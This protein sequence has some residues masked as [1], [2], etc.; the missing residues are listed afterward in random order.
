MTLQGLN[1]D[2]DTWAARVSEALIRVEKRRRLIE[3]K[4]PMPCEN[5]L[6]ALLPRDSRDRLRLLNFKVWSARYAVSLD[7][8]LEQLLFQYFKKNRRLWA[9][10]N[11]TLGVA[12]SALTGHVARRFIE[13]AALREFPNRENLRIM[14][15]ASIPPPMRGFDYQENPDIFVERYQRVML[16][17]QKRAAEEPTRPKYR[18]NFRKKDS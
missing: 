11:I 15:Q 4:P 12:V 9:F 6:C 13:E 5:V 18:R 7:F 8:I 1:T 14:K 2:I 17:R 16:S 10:P 3:G